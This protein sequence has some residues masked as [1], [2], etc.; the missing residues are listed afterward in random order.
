MWTELC[1]DDLSLCD[2]HRYTTYFPNAVSHPSLRNVSG[3]FISPNMYI[4]IYLSIYT[5]TG[6]PEFELFFELCGGW[7]EVPHVRLHQKMVGPCAIFQSRFSVRSMCLSASILG[8]SGRT[9][10]TTFYVSQ[11]IPIEPHTGIWLLRVA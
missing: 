11:D 8:I 6:T 2:K 10:H 3:E 4:Y 9:E 7:V 5:C 1:C